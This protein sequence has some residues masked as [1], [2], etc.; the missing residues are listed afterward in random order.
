MN[1]VTCLGPVVAVLCA[2]AFLLRSRAPRLA[3]WLLFVIA[4]L[5][6]IELSWLASIII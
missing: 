4:G 5:L 6:G 2:T 3:H 1:P